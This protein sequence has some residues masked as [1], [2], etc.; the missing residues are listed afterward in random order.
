MKR[1]NKPVWKRILAS[2]FM[3]LLLLIICI[4]LTKATMNIKRKAVISNERLLQAH[5]ELAKLESRKTDLDKKVS[6]LSTDYGIESEIRTKYRA[7]KDGESLAV[8]IEQN[9]VEQSSSTASTTSP[10][11]GWFRRMFRSLKI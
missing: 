11:Y 6:R 9:N 7:V 3:L 10:K 4:I 1:V 8:I 2:P 5:A